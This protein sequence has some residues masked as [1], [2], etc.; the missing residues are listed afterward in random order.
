MRRRSNSE[1]ERGDAVLS[2]SS[3]PVPWIGVWRS[4]VLA[5]A[6]LILVAAVAVVTMLGAAAL[7]EH[8]VPSRHFD[9][10]HAVHEPLVLG[11]L[12]GLSVLWLLPPHPWARSAKE[13][14]D[15]SPA[16]SAGPTKAAAS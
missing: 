1:N 2:A 16:T 14:T 4:T 11:L 8:L 6:S 9:V 15:H 10:F 3:T 7:V 12:V 13:L 5:L